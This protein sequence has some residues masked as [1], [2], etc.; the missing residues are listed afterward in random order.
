MLAAVSDALVDSK[1]V[2]P[3]IILVVTIPSTHVI[4]TF[5]TTPALSR[6]HPL[7]RIIKEK[8]IQLGRL[9]IEDATAWEWNVYEA[10]KGSV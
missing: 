7:R 9:M 8:I 1:Q 5:L 4:D 6:F 10:M 3:S 2:Y